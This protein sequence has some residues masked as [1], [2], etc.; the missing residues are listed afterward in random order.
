MIV[1]DG[2]ALQLGDRVV[3]LGHMQA[4]VG[5]RGTV[6]TIYPA[7]GY[8]CVVFDE[9]F[10]GGAS[11]EKACVKRCAAVVR[12]EH[13]LPLYAV[14]CESVTALNPTASSVINGPV[15]KVTGQSAKAL[16]LG[17]TPLLGTKPTT[18][19]ATLVRSQ[20][21]AVV[22][23][24]AQQQQQQQQ[25]QA[26]PLTR[27]ATTTTTTTTSTGKSDAGKCHQWMLLLLCDCVFVDG[28]FVLIA[29]PFVD[30]AILSVS[31]EPPPTIVLASSG[32]I[33]HGHSHAHSKSQPHSRPTSGT[34]PQVKPTTTTPIVAPPPIP[35]D[36][37][38]ASQQSPIVKVSSQL[39]TTSTVTVTATVTSTTTA[40]TT[41]TTT[42]PATRPNFQAVMSV[43][44]GQ[45]SVLPKK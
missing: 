43:L 27:A 39:N 36:V 9:E 11:I 14:G 17:F 21:T 28:G 2:C 38:L 31:H 35:V 8:V 44:S 34:S 1:A 29:V 26:T 24:K 40:A 23:T 13:L 42:T 4:P 16:Q 32:S 6:V 25:Q 45:S 30:P 10:T 33:K 5:L 37:K 7:T 19:S 20:T 3:N 12:W 41:T 18:G 15:G 22:I